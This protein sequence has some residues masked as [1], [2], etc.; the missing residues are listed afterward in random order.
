M[1]TITSGILYGT[2]ADEALSAGVVRDP[3][4]N[5]DVVV[6]TV[7]GGGGNDTLTAANVPFVFKGVTYDEHSQLVGEDGNDVLVGGIREM[8]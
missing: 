6:F 8:A 1:A 2:A 4:T 3:A 7:F 5:T